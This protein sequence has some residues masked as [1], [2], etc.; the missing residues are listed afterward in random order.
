MKPL[1]LAELRNGPGTCGE[2]TE[3]LQRAGHNVVESMVHQALRSLVNSDLVEE[4][5]TDPVRNLTREF[6][7]EGGTCVYELADGGVW[8][9]VG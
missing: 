7:I 2:L 9:E 8:K 3:R 4:S 5:K 1:I 6:M